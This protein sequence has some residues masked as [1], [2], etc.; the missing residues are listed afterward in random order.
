L[1]SDN[2]GANDKA[3]LSAFPYLAAPHI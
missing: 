1:T 3:F 2:V